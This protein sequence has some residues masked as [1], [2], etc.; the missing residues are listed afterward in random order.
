[1]GFFDD[2]FGKSQA[3]AAKRA[4]EDT[5]NKQRRS[6]EELRGAG[7][8]YL[9]NLLGLSQRYDPYVQGGGKAQN[10]LYALLGLQ[11]QPA[12]TSAFGQFR[13]DPGYQY[14][15]DQGLQAVDRGAAARSGVRSGATLKAE[16]QSGAN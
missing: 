3:D 11:G 2:L 14:Q 8:D 12:Q 9:S 15:L 6:Q 13:N 7:Q 16:Q 1:M 5:Y 10:Q 4:A